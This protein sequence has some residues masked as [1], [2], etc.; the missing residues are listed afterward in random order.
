MFVNECELKNKMFCDKLHIVKAIKESDC[1]K[2]QSKAI[3]VEYVFGIYRTVSNYSETLYKQ[4]TCLSVVL[5]KVAEDVVSKPC[6][7]K[8]EYPDHLIVK[9]LIP[10][11]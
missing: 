10:L 6:K 2:Q 8:K 5:G 9:I 11:T 4:E 1:Q 7:K 3:F